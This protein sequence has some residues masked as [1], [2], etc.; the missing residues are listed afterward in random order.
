[1]FVYRKI[2]KMVI[3]LNLSFF[4]FTCLSPS[5][6]FAEKKNW[7]VSDYKKQLSHIER[8]PALVVAIDDAIENLP[9]DAKTKTEIDLYLWKLVVL[10]KLNRG[11]EAAEV[12][13]KLQNGFERKAYRDEK[14]YGRTMYQ[15]VESLV[16]TDEIAYSYRIIQN[17]RESVYESPNTFLEFI[18]DRALIEVYIET[19]DYKR[20]LDVSL[21]VLNHPDYQSI[22]DLDNYRTATIN[23]VAFLYNKLGDGNNAIAYIERAEKSLKQS[24]YQGSK[25]L[26]ANAR[27]SGNRA[28][29][30]LH[31]GKNEEAYALGQEVLKAGLELNEKYMIALGHRLVG[32]A[33]YREGNHE[34][35]LRSL[36]AGLDLVH[37]HNILIMKQPIYK[38][39]ALSLE[40][41]GRHD[42]ALYW[43]RKLNAL[44]MKIYEALTITRERLN[45][46]EFQAF[47]SHQELEKLRQEN[48]TQKETY[49]SQQDFRNLLII[50]VFSL[51]VAA[52][53]LIIIL[54]YMRKSQKM[55]RISEQNAQI[56][57]KA[58]T[59]FLATMSHEIRTPMNGVIGMAQ[60]LQNTDLTE[61]QKHYVDIM[62]R[63]GENLLVI[64]NDILDF[65]KIEANQLELNLD[66]HN[67]EQILDDVISLLRHKAKNKSI[68]MAFNYDPH[69]PKLFNVDSHRLTQV[70]TNLL[71]NAI[72]FTPKGKITVRVT[73]D[74]KSE[75]DKQNILIEIKD[76]GIGI[77][78][79]KLKVIFD[80]FTQA[81]SSTTRKFGGTGLGLAI[82]KRIVEAMDGSLKVRSKL[83]KG[84]TFII[85]LPLEIASLNERPSRQETTPIKL[86]SVSKEPSNDTMKAQVKTEV[87]RSA[88]Q[89]QSENNKGAVRKGLRILV[90]EDDDINITVIKSMLE[91]PKIDLTIAKNGKEG[92]RAFSHER[93]DLI[94]MDV[95]MPIM[96]G[97]TATKLIR[98]KERLEGRP[99]TPII[100]LSAHVMKHQQEEFI[101]SGMDDLLPKPIQKAKLL[102]A[103]RKW[104][105]TPKKSVK[106]QYEM[107]S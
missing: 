56:A 54:Y 72:K 50:L 68:D 79:E 74:N 92:V 45:D 94:L 31:L 32:T 83:G 18:I 36:E 71:G 46:V 81:E 27:N 78:K 91:H 14:H 25:L 37:E 98:E 34:E 105:A 70:L 51:L 67:L 13:Y 41:V 89:R 84:S 16:K 86:A 39:Y 44:E 8:S 97:V 88:I 4:I 33:A 65:S 21:F 24:N 73:Q 102:S 75:H 103:L 2:Q 19:F 96:D 107:A 43:Q 106:S 38:T 10:A 52:A 22:A 7:N 66:T 90:V 3:L 64:I 1:M 104:V 49:E 69:L 61:Q 5:I 55:L 20:A 17:L 100:C 26:K 53:F 93:Y 62:T 48:E 82:S 29:A 101:S 85:S 12:A 99:H 11:Q 42:E 35:A 87:K 80:K 76:T 77:S 23:E 60:V 30:Y 6:A 57:N 59:E 95:S 47:K 58:K 15:I 28:R 40:A 63:S 9:S